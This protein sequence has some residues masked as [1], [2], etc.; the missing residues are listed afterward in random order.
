MPPPQIIGA[1]VLALWTRR[2]ICNPLFTPSQTMTS[3]KSTLSKRPSQTSFAVTSVSRMLAIFASFLVNNDADR[4][5]F[6]S[7][8][9]MLHHLTLH[10]IMLH[11]LMHHQQAHASNYQFSLN[12]SCGSCHTISSFANSND[13]SCLHN[14][15]YNITPNFSHATIYH[16]S[17]IIDKAHRYARTTLQPPV[18]PSL[19]ASQQLHL[20]I[21]LVL[22]PR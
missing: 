4:A 7:H 21:T 17:V 3:L 16:T 2:S 1:N 10:H 8:H 6:N 18:P 20:M 13:G 5:L 22:S 12:S 19:L 15:H 14:C 11:H 9:L